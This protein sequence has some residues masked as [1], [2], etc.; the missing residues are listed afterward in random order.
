[1]PNEHYKA[2]FAAMT[3]MPRREA[4]TAMADAIKGQM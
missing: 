3:A 1:V 2:Q 4:L